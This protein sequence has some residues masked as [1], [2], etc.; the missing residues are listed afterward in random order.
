MLDLTAVRSGL[1]A[2][3]MIGKRKELAHTM[4]FGEKCLCASSFFRN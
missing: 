1:L 3:S 4:I 2:S